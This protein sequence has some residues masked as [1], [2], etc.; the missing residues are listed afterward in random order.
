M[1]FFNSFL[2]SRKRY[3]QESP[4]QRQQEKTSIETQR[5]QLKKIQESLQKL[6]NS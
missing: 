2:D 1:N 5:Q 6:I 3:Q 4:E